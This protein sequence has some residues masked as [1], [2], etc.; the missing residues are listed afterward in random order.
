MRN[1]L[2]IVLALLTVASVAY[3][4]LDGGKRGNSGMRTDPEIGSFGRQHSCGRLPRFL[5][6]HGIRPPVLID[7]SQQRYTGVALRYGR[8]FS[9]VMHPGRWERFG[10][11]GTYALDR[12]GDIYLAPMPYISI[13]PT[14]FTLQTNIYRLDSD[15][16]TLSIWM[17]LEDVKPGATNPFGVIS[18]IYDC[19]DETL[20]VSAVDKSDYTTQRGRIYHIDTKSRSVLHTYQG[21]DALTL[22]LLHTQKGK[23]LLAGSARDNGVYAFRVTKEGLLPPVRL[24]SLP[25]ATLRVRKIK[26][27]GENLLQL[28]AV[29]F[30]YTLIVERDS[31]YR[32]LYRA[33]KPA[34]ESGW[35]ILKVK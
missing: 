16:G 34:G 18:L 14:T 6:K 1:Y 27:A 8:G 21:F 12:K 5:A 26:V 13:A 23:Y 3:F 31:T 17:H 32:T 22:A 29:P 7:L 35:K 15:K 11:F 24:F 28:E 20:W 33:F 2:S 10:H 25:D 19:D 9:Q 30:S 4:A